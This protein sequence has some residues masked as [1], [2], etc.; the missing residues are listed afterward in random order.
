M[1]TQEIILLKKIGK[2]NLKK[3]FMEMESRGRVVGETKLKYWL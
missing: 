2:V 3:R 1:H